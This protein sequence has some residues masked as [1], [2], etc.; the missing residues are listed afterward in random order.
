MPTLT[1]EQKQDSQQRQ[2]GF[3]KEY[4]DLIEK[5]DYDFI[6]FPMF[7]PNEKGNFETY[8][9]NQAVDKKYRPVPSTIIPNA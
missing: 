1:D 7:V 5:Y 2:E 8:I 6:S 4:G 9:Q 3:L